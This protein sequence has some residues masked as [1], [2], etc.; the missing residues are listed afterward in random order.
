MNQISC[1]C[2]RGGLLLAAI[3]SCSTAWGDCSPIVI[4]VGRNGIDLGAA[5][6]A[7]NFDVDNNGIPNHVQWVKPGGDEAFLAVDRNGNGVVDNGGGGFG[8][9]YPEGCRCA[10]YAQQRRTR[11]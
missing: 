6:V 4:D 11:G 3:L 8:V 7:V 9:W 5:G 1:M 10:Q 2:F